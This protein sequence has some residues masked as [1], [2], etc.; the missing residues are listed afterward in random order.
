V[1][2]SHAK[3]AGRINIVSVSQHGIQSAVLLAFSVVGRLSGGEYLGKGGFE[4]CGGLGFGVGGSM[5][6]CS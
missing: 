2:K 1:S 3:S 6:S 4:I 5:D